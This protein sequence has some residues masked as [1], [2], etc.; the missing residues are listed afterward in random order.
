MR[1]SRKFAAC[2][3]VLFLAHIAVSFLPSVNARSISSDIVQLLAALLACAACIDARSRSTQYAR[4]FWLMMSTTCLLWAGSQSLSMYY[5]YVAHWNGPTP[6]ASG[7]AF[8]L[9]FLPMFLAV[10]L[11]ER[12]TPEDE[13][14]WERV[15]DT[16]QVTVLI[17]AVY[18]IVII[19]PQTL[20]N[21]RGPD[22]P[23][24]V[25]LNLRNALLLIAFAARWIVDGREST[26]RLLRP[27]AGAFA[28][29]AGGTFFANR[30][31]LLS[32]SP[33]GN[34]YDLTWSVPFLLFAVFAE[35]WTAEEE[36]PE[37]RWTFG[38]FGLAL[39][40]LPSMLLPL[41]LLKMYRLVV[42]EQVFVGLFGLTISAVLYTVR[43]ALLAHRQNAVTEALQS[44]ENRYRSLFDRNMAGVFRSSMDGKLLEFNEAFAQ[45]YGYSREELSAMSTYDLYFG[46]EEERK[47]LIEARRVD[48]AKQFEVRYK[49]KDG[50]V[51][52]AVQN[53]TIQGAKDGTETIEGTLI[54]IT[55]R[56]ALEDQLRQAQ[57]MEAVGRLAGGVAHDFNNLLTVITGYSQMQMEETSPGT[58]L[59]EHAQQVY[60]ASQRAAALTRQLLAFSRQQVL[61][62]EVVSLNTIIEGMRK[63]LSRL[64]GEDIRV[65]TVCT[66]EPG[67]VMVDPAQIEQAVMNLSINARDAMPKGGQL[68]IET[69]RVE[70]DESYTKDH[71]YVKPGVFMRLTVSDSGIGMDQKTQARIFEPFF[72]TKETGKGTGLGLSTVYGVVKQSGGHIQVYSEPGIGTTF[73]L[74][75]PVVEKAA[76]TREIKVKQVI[77]RRGKETILVVE[78]DQSLREL[79]RNILASQG[80]TVFA[81]QHPDEVRE[82]CQ[83][84]GDKIDLLLTDVIM[85]QMSGKDVAAMCTG[86]IPKLKVLYMSGYTSDVIMHHGVLEEGLAFLQKPFTPVGLTAKVREV[87]DSDVVRT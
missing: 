26:R 30:W 45:M 83:E 64:I 84:I 9:S 29:Y 21:D 46:G 31:D 66:S 76:E 75:F 63:M 61:Q 38:Y 52:L 33:A 79:A 74:Y 18:T 73:K 57:K 37:S 42:K 50:T 58:S 10:L 1:N 51:L 82:I 41:L 47:R 11:P 6:I 13:I 44:S 77:Q 54:D 71:P 23:R 43:V 28:L 68:T 65:R 15:I 19:V 24:L 62:P 25:A 22:A 60:E 7:T 20:N 16:F 67:L 4:S 72:T 55:R 56:A 3:G 69:D 49:K 39:V 70:L 59:Y 80:Y 12:N 87:L 14:D 40:Y 53:V 35:R 17:L 78:D 36:S 8:F 81:A 27:V 34:L 5:F 48:P 85:P 32:V 86:M 2:A